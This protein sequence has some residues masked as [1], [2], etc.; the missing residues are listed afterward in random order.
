MLHNLIELVPL[1]S[2]LEA[3]DAADGQKALQ[4]G[5]DCVRIVGAEELEGEVEESGPLFGEIVLQDLL[6]KRNQLGANIMRGRGQ[7]RD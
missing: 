6:E 4:P 5:V 3:I 1:L 2:S 7:G